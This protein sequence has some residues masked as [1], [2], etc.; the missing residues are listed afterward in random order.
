[1]VHAELLL[2]AGLA[3]YLF[4]PRNADLQNALAGR[5]G[6]Q[7]S[8]DVGMID[9]AAARQIVADLERQDEARKAEEEKKQV[10]SVHPPGQVVDLP[11]PLEEKRPDDAKFVSEHDSTVTHQTKK[12]GRFE[13]HARQGDREGT[14]SMP[15]KP[16][17]PGDD[18]RLAMRTPDLGRFLRTP[19][20]SGAPGRAG[21][22]GS[23]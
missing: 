17:A 1:L 21:R 3:F 20:L 18:R 2:L 10:E 23:R 16:S 12:Y 4:A 7:E 6:E 15:Q 22:P 8:I 13:D 11:T 19:G 5:G 14:A 9:E